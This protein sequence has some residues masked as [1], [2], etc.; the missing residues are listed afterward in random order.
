MNSP[1]HVPDLS[2]TIALVTGATSGIGLETAARLG[3]AGADVI[4]AVRDLTKARRVVARLREAHR[5]AAFRIEQVDLSDLASIRRAAGQINDQ[6]RPIDILVNNAG[7]MSGSRQR[8]TTIDGFELHLGTNFLGAFALTGLLLPSLRLAQ[9]ARIVSVG[10]L[11]AFRGTLGLGPDLTHRY[12]PG[13]AY[14][15]SKLALTTFAVELQRRSDHQGWGLTST[16][17]HPGW[18]ATNINGGRFSRLGTVMPLITRP[19]LAALPTLAAATLPDVPGGSAIGPE[20]LLQLRGAPGIVPLPKKAL[21]ADSAARLW[22]TAE[23][24]TGVF[25]PED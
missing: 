23:Q 19:D 5:E 22:R 12:S 16:I 15:R 11:T 18:A 24:M 6:G 14:A 17:A 8:Q 9:G 7:V 20:G 13:A 4:L 10:S 25:W 2:G 1:V 3:M 21:D